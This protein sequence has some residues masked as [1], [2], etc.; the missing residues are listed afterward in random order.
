MIIVL[1]NTFVSINFQVIK[2]QMEN[3]CIYWYSH[4]RVP[5]GKLWCLDGD[6]AY[7]PRN[8]HHLKNI[9][10]DS[11]QSKFK[12]ILV[13]L[14][15]WF[16]LFRIIRDTYCEGVFRSVIL[17]SGPSGSKHQYHLRLSL[18]GKFLPLPTSWVRISRGGAHSLPLIFYRL[19]IWELLS[20]RGK[21]I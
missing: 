2:M 19:K 11:L 13:R 12:Q 10:S 8:V 20:L 14:I 17:C 15:Y 6:T 21:K 18:K 9:S 3:I 5:W 7:S 1:G 4:L 16:S